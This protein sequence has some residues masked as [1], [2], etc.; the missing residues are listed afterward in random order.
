M[1]TTRLSLAT[2]VTLLATTVGATM[3]FAQSNQ[4]A[5]SQHPGHGMMGSGDMDHGGMMNMGQMNRMI[6]NCK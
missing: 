3:V 6:D 2:A 5:P 4:P 1:K